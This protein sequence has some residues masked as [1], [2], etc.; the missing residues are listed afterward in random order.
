MFIKFSPFSFL[1]FSLYLCFF[2]VLFSCSSFYVYW[3]Y[4]EFIS[5]LFI[6]VCYTLFVSGMSN[7]I[8]YFLVQAAASMRIFVF[9]LLD[10]HILVLASL[11]I[12]LGLFPFFS[13]YISTIHIFPNFPFVVVS[14]LHKLP[15]LL[16]SYFFLN[17]TSSNFLHAIFVLNFLL[18]VV[19]MYRVS[20]LRYL[21]V[22]SSIPN[23][24]WMVIAC[25]MHDILSLVLFCFVYFISFFVFL[26]LF[27]T[28][29]SLSARY[30]RSGFMI[31]PFLLLINL[32]AIPPFP[33]FYT[34][35]LVGISYYSYCPSRFFFISVIFF[36][37]VL[38]MIA[39]IQVRFRFL[40]VYI[41]SPSLFLLF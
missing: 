20:D 16:V 34:K 32:A 22:V 33:I 21:L 15:P 35:F 2:P 11:F 19:I 23:T 7:L 4:I 8:V 41:T 12:K 17:C 25:L 1:F 29:T 30:K 40:F 37:N 27:K 13:W 39:Y 24:V 18:A 14:T 38:G 10:I 5:L 36:L 9:Y 6:G 28:S 3:L 31:V 26:T